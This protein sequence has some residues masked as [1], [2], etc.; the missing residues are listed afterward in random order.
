M[1]GSAVVVVNTLPTAFNVTGG[2]SYCTGGFGLHVYLSGSNSG[3]NYQLYMG[4]VP[5]GLPVAGTGGPIAMGVHI[6]AGNYT[7]SATNATTGCTAN[8]TGS[9]II[10]INPLPTIYPL[11]GGGSYCAGDT[12]MH[13]MLAGSDAGISYQLMHGSSLVGSPVTGTGGALDF[14]PITTAGVYTLAARNVFT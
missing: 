2:G 1:T 6:F 10:A 8:M 3:V 12:G 11:T 5:A 13:I 14:G 9:A 4:G 7:V